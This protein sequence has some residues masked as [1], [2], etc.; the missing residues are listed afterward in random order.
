VIDFHKQILERRPEDWNG[1]GAAFKD[2][3]GGTYQV[4]TLIA[5]DGVHPS[6]YKEGR[7]DFSDD[8]ISKNGY[9]LR[10]YLTIQAYADVI[11]QVLKAE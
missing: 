4:S 2:E 9:S 5:R 7:N 8:A 3:P 10:N 11:R 1:G 6:N